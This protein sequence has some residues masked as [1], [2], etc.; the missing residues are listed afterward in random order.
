MNDSI[1]A[2]NIITTLALTLQIIILQ[3]LTNNNKTEWWNVKPELPSQVSFRFYFHFHFHFWGGGLIRVLVRGRGLSLL[4]PPSRPSQARSQRCSSRRPPRCGTGWRHWRRSWRPGRRRCSGW[5]PGSGHWN[6][7]AAQEGRVGGGNY[8][9]SPQ[10]QSVVN[11]DQGNVFLQSFMCRM[12][13]PM[14]EQMKNT[15]RQSDRQS[16][17]QVP[18]ATEKQA[19]RQVVYMFM[20][21]LQIVFQPCLI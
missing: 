14:A 12:V 11:D 18:C 21:G 19:G 16:Y 5:R 13:L 10:Y 9:L 8:L 15:N 4:C 20:F 3:P 7:T 17:K 2:A 1:A 6:G